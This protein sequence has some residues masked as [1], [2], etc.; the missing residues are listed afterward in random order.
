MF[1]QHILADGS[2]AP[3][4]MV[5][6][7]P[8]AIGP[9]A[10]APTSLVADGAGGVFVGWIDARNG[11]DYDLYALR[12][13]AGGAVASGWSPS[14]MPVCIAPGYQY[15]PLLAPDGAGGILA[16]WQDD[17]N[18][19]TNRGIY[20]QHLLADGSIAPSWEPD[21]ISLC[22]DSPNVCCPVAVADG[23]GGFIAAWLDTRNSGTTGSDIY[24]L[25]MSGTGVVASG[26][27]SQGNAVCTAENT[28]V[29]DQLISDG[30]GGAY[31]VWSD[32][33]TGNPNGDG[34][35]IYATR[36]RGNGRIAPGWIA[37]GT[38]VCT[39]QHT[40]QA[41]RL[42]SD[43]LGGVVLTWEDY[44]NYGGIDVYAQRLTP[45]G[46]VAPGWTV[47]G[48]AVVTG[49]SFQFS[50]ELIGDGAGGALIAWQDGR[51]G[52]FDDVF[53]QHLRGDAS[54]A[55][56]WVDGGVRVAQNPASRCCGVLASDMLGG[57]IIAWGAGSGN[58]DIYA[59][60]LTS[61]LPVATRPSLVSATAESGRVLLSW[62]AS[63]GDATSAS[64]Y[65]RSES[66]EWTLLGQAVASGSGLLTFE[67]RTVTPGRYA[68][69]LGYAGATGESF[70]D[71]VWVD[72][73]AAATFALAGFLPNPAHGALPVSFSLAGEGPAML[74]LFNVSGRRVSAREVGSL[75]AG[76]HL[77]PLDPATKLPG[78]VYW[79]R[80]TQGARTATVK[81][82][83]VGP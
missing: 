83:V 70:T 80:L 34:G 49:N 35:D 10:V 60:H 30:A 50:P 78:G 17:R 38:P 41:A 19:E 25:R 9:G 32:Y 27:F 18:G 1:L 77:V 51:D 71:E 22:P 63:E 7:N 5:N 4:W 20:A 59:Q 14:G 81:G 76:V 79:L 58:G 6:G 40:Q 46:S 37:D 39:V 67:D 52:T 56:G 65:R 45:T 47:D 33:R 57:A 23:A 69:R 73:P 36:I 31:L 28:Q 62:F 11:I 3:G 13:E 53:A 12:V 64:V 72:V 66:S 43:G 82:I 75:G 74:E 44:R 21:G 61:D 8:V 29:P 24:A 55:P 68:Y 26:W 15:G 16:V 54:L 42:A 48:T 2:I